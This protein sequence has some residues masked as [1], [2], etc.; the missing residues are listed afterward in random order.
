MENKKGFIKCKICT[1]TIICGNCIIKLC[2]NGICNKCPVCR[3]EN[4]K[5]NLN[6]TAVVPV[7][8]L[9]YID[10]DTIYED[11]EHTIFQKNIWLN[12]YNIILY[13][14]LFIRSLLLFISCIIIIWGIG[15]ILTMTFISIDLNKNYAIFWFPFVISLSYLIPII[16]CYFKM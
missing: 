6:C 14:Y 2:E 13:I 9:N 5:K 8:K 1:N 10:I 16:C 7:N 11:K 15:I 3:Q 4:W 12:I